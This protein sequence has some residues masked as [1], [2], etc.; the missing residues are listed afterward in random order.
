PIDPP[1]K[2]PRPK[3]A[4]AAAVPTAA[5]PRVMYPPC[6]QAG[7]IVAKVST[8]GPIKSAKAGGVKMKRGGATATATAGGG[9]TTIGG[10]N[11]AP[12]SAP[13]EGGGGSAAAGGT[14]TGG[15]GAAAI[16]G[17]QITGSPTTT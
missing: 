5:K 10:G 16:G 14:A 3:G 15:G 17:G 8:G 4:I 6:H 9:R 7:P 1:T 13:V 11:A 2:P 12:S